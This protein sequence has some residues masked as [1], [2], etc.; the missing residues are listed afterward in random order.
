M[1]FKMINESFD[2]ENCWNL[3]E[4]HP[5]WSARNHCPYCLFS[6]HLDNNDLQIWD[7]MIPNT[8][9]DSSNKPMF[10]EYS[11]WENYDMKKF[12]LILNWICYSWNEK[13]EETWFVPLYNMIISELQKKSENKIKFIF[14]IREESDVF[15]IEE[16]EELKLNN[17]NF[18]FEVYISRVKDLHKFQNK[19]TNIKIHSWYTTNNLTSINTCNYKEIY[20]CWA[21]SMIESSVEKLEKLGFIENENIFYEKY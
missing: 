2:C 3:I 15:K 18:N 13:S 8:F 16:L 6:K 7:I 11:I 4:K 14:W 5:E 21:P 19:H 10:L 12:W 9:I 20:I 1:W 17:P